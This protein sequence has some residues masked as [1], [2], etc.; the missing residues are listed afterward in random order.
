MKLVD[1]K[2]TEGELTEARVSLVNKTDET[3]PTP[4]AIVGCGFTTGAT[5]FT[6][7]NVAT[8]N[9]AIDVFDNPVNEDS[10]GTV[11]TNEPTA[12]QL[13]YFKAERQG[14][15]V[16]LNWAT[17]VELDNFGFRILRS[18]SGSLA[19]AVDLAF[20]PGRGHGTA[21]GA[22]YSFSDKTAAQNR[23]YT[24]WLVD[25][26]FNGLET[27]HGPVAVTKPGVDQNTN[28]SLYLPLILH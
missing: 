24:Y 18:A 9:N 6:M 25:V 10:D 7:T 26:D 11:I 27:F 5:T 16:S 20:I 3:I 8:V 2:I 13:L 14:N 4:L 1:A 12:I 17:A 15:A 28:T 22:S 23:S 19:D 21:S